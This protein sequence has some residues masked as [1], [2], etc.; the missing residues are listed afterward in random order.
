MAGFTYGTSSGNSSGQNYGYSIGESSGQGTSA[1]TGV[2]DASSWAHQD[3]ALLQRYDQ[4]YQ[5][6]LGQHSK[7]YNG[8]TGGYA[9]TLG[10]IG[11][12]ANNIQQGYGQLNQQVQGTIQGIDASQRQAINDAYAQ[13]RGATHQGLI[14]SGLG[15]TTVTASADRGLLADKTKADIALSNQMAQLQAGYQGQFGSAGLAAQSQLM[16]QQGSLGGQYMGTI[17]GQNLAATGWA[18]N[19]SGSLSHG[20]N[21]SQSQNT[22]QSRN[23]SENWGFNQSQNSA[24]NYGAQS[25]PPQQ[26]QPYGNYGNPQSSIGTPYSYT[27]P[28]QQGTSSGGANPPVYPEQIYVPN[29]G[30]SYYDPSRDVYSNPS[31]YGNAGQQGG[32]NAGQITQTYLPPTQNW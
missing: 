7:I 5:D 21:Q 15:N 16:G 1:S 12:Q 10:R 13:Q 18:P 28:N 26:Q 9:D 2:T 23:Q 27:P 4:Q 8:I 3:P 14:S 20:Q 30:Q 25:N 6:Y 17:G 24:Y 22:N 29:V 19:A 11:Q 31:Y 32:A